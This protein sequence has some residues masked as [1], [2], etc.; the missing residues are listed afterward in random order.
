MQCA[1]V[2]QQMAIY[3]ELD[4]AERFLVHDHLDTC[5]ACRAAF[6]AYQNQDR[7]LAN[8]PGL[9]PSPALAQAVLRRTTRRSARVARP[10]PSGA[11][12]WAGNVA[13]AIV[14][15]FVLA[16]TTLSVAAGSLPG[17]ALYSVKR[18]AERARLA[19]TR[20]EASRSRILAQLAA[21]RRAE[22]ARLLKEGRE[23]EVAF[24]GR[25][26]AAS[27]GLWTVDGIPVVFDANTLTSAE[28]AARWGDNPPAPDD[29]LVIEAQVVGG[30]VVAE[31]VLIATPIVGPTNEPP[32]V[33]PTR[34][35]TPAPSA[36]ASASVTL[37]PSATSAQPTK[38][39]SERPI[40]PNNERPTTT[41]DDTRTPPDKKHTPLVE[42]TRTPARTALAETR[43]AR[44]TPTPSS[45][46]TPGASPTA[47]PTRTPKTTWTP[48]PSPTLKALPTLALTDT[49]KPEPTRRKSKP[50]P[51]RA[52]PT[53]QPTNVEP[54]RP[55][56]PTD[57]PPTPRPP[58]PR[59]TDAPAWPTPEPP[60]T[61]W[62]T[63]RPPTPRP[64]E[65]A[66]GNARP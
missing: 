52:E 2:R 9:T 37:S 50:E 45:T 5:A 24:E 13:L 57:E 35:A 33:R 56:E 59:P 19:L 42:R 25:L 40:R 60:P 23:G 63:P 58:T 12:R 21:E 28:I 20:N 66:I 51:T 43:T 1:D 11:R 6:E 16:S 14:A 65:T 29:V 54:T 55:P 46:A 15:L 18:A 26:E 38:E 41:P 48:P 32:V 7:A 36:T 47:S 61:K 34:T 3:R 31:R 64:F 22:V 8:L 17:D 49:P 4:E 62:P 53:R 10:A 44:P 39:P 30:R 27:E